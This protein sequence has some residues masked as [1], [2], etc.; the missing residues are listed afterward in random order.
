MKKLIAKLLTP[1]CSGLIYLLHNRATFSFNRL[2]LQCVQFSFS[3]NGEDICVRRLAYEFNLRKG[4]YVDVGAYHPILGSNTLLLFKE[5]W[6]GINIDLALERVA[7]FNQ[8]RPNDYNVI[9]CVSD[10]TAT[11]QIA[12]YEISAT[13]RIVLAGDTEKLSTAGFKPIRFSHASTTTLTEIIKG[14][15][16]RLEDIQYLNIDCE[17]HDLAVLSGLD[18]QRCRPRILSVEAVSD[19]Q[20]EDIVQFLAPYGYRLEAIIPPTCILAHEGFLTS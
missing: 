16:F 6:R 10:K 11:V 8:Y 4:V 9:A 1:I 19:A 3:W 13:D 7:S 17:L 5:G 18:F 20:R 14:S 15:P 2:E 12:H